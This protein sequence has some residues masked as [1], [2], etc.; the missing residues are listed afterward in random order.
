VK[1][2]VGIRSR[3]L[4]T[5]AISAFVL[6]TMASVVMVETFLRLILEESTKRLLVDS[7]AGACDLNPKVWTKTIPG[8]SGEELPEL[9]I[10][11]IDETK[12]R[13][14]YENPVFVPDWILNR[15]I[16]SKGPTAYLRRDEPTGRSTYVLRRLGGDR[17]CTSF[18]FVFG[19]N[20][21]MRRHIEGMLF[22][23]SCVASA[24]V[25]LIMWFFVIRPVVR[26]LSGLRV[27]AQRVGDGGSYLGKFDEAG[28]D[29]GLIS[30]SLDIAHSRI[31]RDAATLEARRVALE[32][33][34]A[35]VA[36]DL[37]TPM[38][39]L[40]LVLEDLNRHIETGDGRAHL[41][42]AIEDTTY[43][44]VL[45]ENLHMASK[46]SDGMELK[47]I[48]VEVDLSEL[49]ERVAFRFQ[50]LGRGRGI[51]VASARP[52]QP[53]LVNCDPY[54]AERALSNIVHNA[55]VYGKDNG[56]VAVVLEVEGNEF[57]IKV[58]DDGPGVEPAE[59]ELL[60]DR[61]FRSDDARQRD[62]RG[63]GLGLT[64]THEIARRAGWSLGFDIL[65]PS[66]LEVTLRG[67]LSSQ[68]KK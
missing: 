27:N 28:D 4:L 25:V 23:L 30:V 34:L 65:E 7:D 31:C 61:T 47:P 62:S 56:N 21:R 15:L 22:G 59:L 10:Y 44:M 64:I 40:H 45:T 26:R 63:N 17:T 35:N 41:A 8:I 33:H 48:N 46:L 50:L 36:H 18:L 24:F 57:E 20:H 53:V 66:G 54:G 43:L 51:E 2:V 32:H 38:A 6:T 12:R 1:L 68:K 49:V 19:E 16:E 42:R 67:Q 29:I 55:V 13:I 39:S 37:R 58:S 5:A 3:I 52:D 9:H 14:R 60:S 11:S